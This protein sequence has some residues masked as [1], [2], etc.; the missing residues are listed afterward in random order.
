MLYYVA[1][2]ND[3]TLEFGDIDEPFYKSMESMFARL[4]E[5]LIVQKDEI[6]VSEFM[7][8]LESGSEAC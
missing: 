2:G 7:P 6:L 3:F 5:T 1:C 4:V 8:R